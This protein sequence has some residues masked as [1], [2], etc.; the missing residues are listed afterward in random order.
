MTV[1]LFSGWRGSIEW[2]P[3]ECDTKKQLGNKLV[4]KTGMRQKNIYIYVVREVSLVANCGKTKSRCA[5]ANMCAHTRTQPQELIPFKW[6]R[7]AVIPF[8][9]P[10]TFSGSCG[11][12]A[13]PELFGRSYTPANFNNDNDDS[14]KCSANTKINIYFCVCSL[15][16]NLYRSWLF[17]WHRNS[18][19]I[20]QSRKLTLLPAFCDKSRLC[21]TQDNSLA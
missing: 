19:K 20:Q 14:E 16:S 18:N 4:R 7:L 12:F 8:R 10:L 11:T 6:G 2:W 1:Y 13:A 17:I 9:I 15:Y 21:T 3:R 5:T